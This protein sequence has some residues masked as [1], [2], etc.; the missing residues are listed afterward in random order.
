MLGW[1]LYHEC[2]GYSNHSKRVPGKGVTRALWALKNRETGALWSLYFWVTGV[3]RA[4]KEEMLSQTFQ[5][6]FHIEAG[7]SCVPLLGRKILFIGR[8]VFFPKRQVPFLSRQVPFPKR[9]NPV[10]HF[11][12]AGALR[13]LN[14]LYL[15]DQSAL[16]IN[17][18]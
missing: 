18:S 13:A 2:L 4:L 3:F 10:I 15:N 14:S 7:T 17:K 5:Q 16:G 6:L 8:Q 9:I 12:S 1:A 11:F